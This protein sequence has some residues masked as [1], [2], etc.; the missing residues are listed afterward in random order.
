MMHE[1]KAPK[2]LK[3]GSGFQ[4]HERI[5]L[6]GGWQVNDLSSIKQTNHFSTGFSVH[7]PFDLFSPSVDYAFVQEPNNI[8]Y[9]HTFGIQLKL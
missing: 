2:N 9:M 3:I 8:S 7:L 1:N 6:R 5:T 4:L